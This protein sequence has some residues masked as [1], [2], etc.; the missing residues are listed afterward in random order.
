MGN[1]WELEEENPSYKP[2]AHLVLEDSETKS[3]GVVKDCKGAINFIPPDAE[4]VGIWHRYSNGQFW[5][6]ITTPVE[7]L[8][9]HA[10]HHYAKLTELR[11]QRDEEILT[12]KPKAT[13]QPRAP[14]V[15]KPEE[16]SQMVSAIDALRAK[17]GGS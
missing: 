6:D 1:T 2:K 14:K 11:R 13:R 15:E 10:V 3:W 12:V 8:V 5:V 9:D 16:P 17:L 4:P 7:A